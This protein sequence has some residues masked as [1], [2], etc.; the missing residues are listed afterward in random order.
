MSRDGT[1]LKRCGSYPPPDAMTLDTAYRV[2]VA[3]L[4][5]GV[6]LGQAFAVAVAQLSDG[7]FI[8]ALSGQKTKASMNR[9]RIR[10]PDGCR[11]AEDT[12]PFMQDANCAKVKDD[13]DP[14]GRHCAE[15]KIFLSKGDHL[16]VI[17][18]VTFWY[19]RTNRHP[20]PG[21]EAGPGS[22]MFPCDSCLQHS[23]RLMSEPWLLRL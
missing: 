13:Q 2:F 19:G 4:Q 12:V 10:L 8:V 3:I 20:W 11:W 22:L 23:E 1:W 18:Q 9:N 6:G 15:P 7:G 21:H 17:S 14:R 16:E 5:A